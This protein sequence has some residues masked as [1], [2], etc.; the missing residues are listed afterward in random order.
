M[1][2]FV[3]MVVGVR[4]GVLSG[5]WLLVCWGTF[6]MRRDRVS[7]DVSLV[8]LPEVSPSAYGVLEELTSAM[9]VPRSVLAP[10][11]EIH[12]AWREL[13][14]LLTRIPHGKRNE[15]MVRLCVAVSVGLFDAAINYMWNATVMELRLR[16]EYFGLEH[17]GAVTN[18]EIT[19]ESLDTLHDY[20]LLDLAMEL[21]ILSDKGY[22]LLDQCRDL[23]NNFSAAHPAKGD[24]DQFE[25]VNFV[26]RCVKYV[27]QEGGIVKGLD[28]RS[29]MKAIKSGRFID[30]QLESWALKL[31][32]AHEIQ[33]SAAVSACHGIYCDQNSPQTA[34]DNILDLLRS[35]PERLSGESIG[36]ALGQHGMYVDAG[37]DEK[38]KASRQFFEKLGRLGLLD[39]VDKYSLISTACERLL[40][41]HLGYNNFYAEPP[42]AERLWELSRQ[43]SRPTSI[44]SRYVEVIV[45]CAI[46]NSYGVSYGALGYYHNLV[47]EFTPR[48]VAIMLRLPERMGR[49]RC[50]LESSSGCRARFRKL[51]GLVSEE[52]VPTQSRVAYKRWLPGENNAF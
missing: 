41:S 13:S 38:I 40:S 47:R 36:K 21:G 1:V 25:L 29:L 15:L 19:E 51:A 11:D 3:L 10:V 4:S 2:R 30:E 6:D 46:G 8:Q 16:V 28:H 12:G 35:V 42:Y 20:K 34:R 27:F 50:R 49:V 17:A 44:Q 14:G 31:K 43:I 18:R 33:R 24:L 5:C 39:E 48:E 32:Q 22:H 9:G 26:N 23:R 7:D 45:L 37:D 52:A